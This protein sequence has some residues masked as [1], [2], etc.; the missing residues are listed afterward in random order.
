MMGF[1]K[2]LFCG[3]SWIKIKEYHGSSLI[4]PDGNYY[5]APPGFRHP[6]VVSLGKVNQYECEKCGKNIHQF[7]GGSLE[8]EPGPESYPDPE[9]E[10]FAVHAFPK[11]VK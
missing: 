9:G 6:N 7:H 5:P 8:N 10:E 11:P 2:R 3:H 4:S 1:W